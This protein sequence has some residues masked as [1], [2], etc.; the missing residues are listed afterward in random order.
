MHE[1]RQQQRLSRDQNPSSKKIKKP[2]NG[3]KPATKDAAEPLINDHLP[4]ATSPANDTPP[5]VDP[6]D[7]APSLSLPLLPPEQ[8][9]RQTPASLANAVRKH[10]NAQQLNEAETIAKFLYVVRDNGS[11]ASPRTA[12]SGGDGHGWTMGSQGREVRKGEGG[13]VGFRLRFRP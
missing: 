2:S 8:I 3:T 9:A 12:G 6:I 11:R 1:F 13:E 7:T 4:S 5:D 10:F